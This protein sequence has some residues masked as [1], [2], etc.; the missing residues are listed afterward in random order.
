M[1]R[2]K[3]LLKALFCTLHNTIKF[4]LNE[5]LLNI[6]S[7]PKFKQDKMHVCLVSK[8]C[9]NRVVLPAPKNPASIV[10]GKD[11]DLEYVPSFGRGSLFMS[12]S[13]LIVTC[14][15]R[16]LLIL[17]ALCFVE[18][19]MIKYSNIYRKDCCMA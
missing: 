5:F 3:Q 4:K 1:Q 2:Q 10:T 7:R 8:M 15:F 12:S 17:L 19:L 6:L 9:F 13:A 14:V 16:L 18:E 11:V